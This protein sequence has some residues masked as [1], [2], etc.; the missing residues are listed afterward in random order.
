MLPMIVPPILRKVLLYE[1]RK[2]IVKR[3]NAI[4]NI[5]AMDVFL[6]R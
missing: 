4:Q 5:G 6:H 1:Q 3:L 2:V